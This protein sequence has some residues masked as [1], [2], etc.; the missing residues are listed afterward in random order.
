MC[1]YFNGPF[2]I[3]YMPFYGQSREQWVKSE[4]DIKSDA[5][6]FAVD[7]IKYLGCE[8]N[9]YSSAPFFTPER[10]SEIIADIK[11]NLGTM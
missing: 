10:Y 5:T 9:G 11:K 3:L 4:I 6:N 7:Q 2:D 1:C 8:I